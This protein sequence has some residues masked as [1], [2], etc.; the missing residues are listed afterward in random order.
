MTYEQAV[1]IVVLSYTKGRKGGN[2]VCAEVLGQLGDPHKKL[3]AVHVAGTN[4]KGSTCALLRSVLCRAGYRTG[5][6][7][8]PHLCRFNE[9]FEIDGAPIS[10]GDFAQLTETVVSAFMEVY[11]QQ[12][13]CDDGISISYY[14]LLTMMAFVYFVEKNVDLAIIEV[15]LGGRLD[16]T[17]ILE[18]P[19]LSIITKIGY[20]HMDQLGNS[21]LEITAEK[22]GII[23]PGVPVALFHQAKE[24]HNVTRGVCLIR[25]AALHYPAGLETN[26]INESLEGIEFSAKFDFGGQTMSWEN[27]KIGMIGT[28]QAYNAANVLNVLHVL[29]GLGY[30]IEDEALH[31][32]F[33]EAMWPGR[34]EILA[35]DPMIIVDGAHNEDGAMAVRDFMQKYL[36]GKDIILLTAMLNDKDHSAILPVL[37]EAANKIILTTPRFAAKACDPELLRGVLAGH[38]KETLVIHDY[39]DALDKAKDLAGPDSVIFVAGS[40]Y[41][42]GDV[43]AIVD[44][45]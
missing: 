31:R 27:L 15:G 5:M 17:N 39:K 1:E 40:L 18:K 36:S 28:H 38:N 41:L 32:G 6:F 24:V 26:I 43:K 35:R 20:D 29:R 3:R 22:C 7:T 2:D 12:P 16:A 30:N 33:A 8:S 4:A 19:V 45:T 25:D 21:I 37:A 42:V 44:K 34:M 11:G 23:K 10:D 9:R 13:F 14:E